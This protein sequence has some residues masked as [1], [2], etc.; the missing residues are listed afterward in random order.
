MSQ[1]PWIKS[2]AAGVWTQAETPSVIE[3]RRREE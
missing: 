3:H 2:Y 1:M